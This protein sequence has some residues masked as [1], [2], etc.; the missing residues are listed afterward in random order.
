MKRSLKNK[1]KLIY[2]CLILTIA[3]IGIVSVM[4]FSSLSESIDTVLSDNYKSINASNIMINSIDKQNSS[5]FYY[6]H[7]QKQEAIDEFY[8]NKNIFDKY[9][10]IEEN[11]RT[12]KGEKELTEKINTNYAD[13]LML[14]SKIQEINSSQ[15]MTISINYYNQNVLP[16]LNKITS[17][18]ASLSIINENAMYK[19]RD[20]LSSRAETYKYLIFIISI[21]AVIGGIFFSSFF[22]NRFLFPICELTET[23]KSMGQG[24][25]R[26]EAIVTS[27]DEIG[28]LAQEFNKMTLRLEEYEQSTMGKFLTEKNKFSAIIKTLA[29]PLIV[30]DKDQ[31]IVLLNDACQDFFQM[32]EEAV[33]NKYFID[34]MDNSDLYH[35]ISN[36][37]N[38]KEEN[39]AKIILFKSQST[40]YYFNVITTIIKDNSASISGIVVLFQNITQLKQLE[41]IKTDFI[42]TISHEFKTPLTSIMMGASLIEDENI[43]ALNSQQHKIIDT[44][45]EDGERLSELVTNLLQLSRIEWSKSIFNMRTCSILGIV[46]QSIKGFYDQATTKDI[47]LFIDV[48]EHLPKIF[49]DPE[50]INWVL[51]N[52]LSNALKYTN[53]GDE[54]SVSAK[55]S[56]GKMI[57][58]VK[59]TG[60]GIPKEYVENIFDQFVQV[61]GYD[62]EV[63]GTGLGLTIA[64]EIVEAHNGEIWCES[65]IDVGSSFT[66]TLPLKE[67]ESIKP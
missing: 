63:R 61:K 20:L 42:S 50:K 48:D 14:F 3:I 51:N 67:K 13:F 52:L 26:K 39:K 5:M 44:I 41:K 66:F 10:K 33:I 11:N 31:K 55:V 45:K 19:N 46:E 54:L 12:E 59:D 23:I 8:K 40:D 2:L 60:A 35:H 9:Y 4:N 17:D 43:G 58:C 34:V 38:D 15:G 29:D 32:K 53:A 37:L 36:V 16:V 62:S 56:H 27:K 25:L 22:I 49:A 28:Q 65:H 18:L 47:N 1:F 30:L 64:K 57:V 6:I 7:S 21:I 24:H